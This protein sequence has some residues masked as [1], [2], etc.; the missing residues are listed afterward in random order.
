MWLTNGHRVSITLPA[1]S[2]VLV[3]YLSLQ[4]SFSFSLP[5][6]CPLCGIVIGLMLITIPSS[7]RTSL[8]SDRSWAVCWK[9]RDVNECMQSMTE[10]FTLL[11]CVF[12]YS[13]CPLLFTFPM[14][15]DETKGKFYVRSQLLCPKSV[16]KISSTNLTQLA[17]MFVCLMVVDLPYSVFFFF[18]GSC[19]YVKPRLLCVII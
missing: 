15:G 6:L 10:R 18:H 2:L 14:T 19:R 7:L 1:T 5:P 9:H 8:L 16:S 17:F 4:H 3:N 12:M 11:V 13:S